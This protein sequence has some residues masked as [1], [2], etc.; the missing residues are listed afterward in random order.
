[1]CCEFTEVGVILPPCQLAFVIV[2]ISCF[3][4]ACGYLARIGYFWKI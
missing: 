1:M 4:A 2:K 3:A